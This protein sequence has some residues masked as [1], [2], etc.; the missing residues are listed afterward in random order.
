MDSSV[1]F[2]LSC[3]ICYSFRVVFEFVA[4]GMVWIPGVL[5]CYAKERLERLFESGI[6]STKA[7][8]RTGKS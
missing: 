8:Y 2:I 5:L 7:V 3:D 6:G 4:T 1:T